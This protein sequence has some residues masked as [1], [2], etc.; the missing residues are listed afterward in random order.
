MRIERER[1]MSDDDH[2][3]LSLPSRIRAVAAAVAR[4]AY[5]DEIFVHA[6]A[7]TYYALLSIVPLLALVFAMVKA[8]GGVEERLD[9]LLRMFTADPAFTGKVVEF[10]RQVHVG[11]LTGLSSAFLL[12]TAY[13]LLG[14]IEATFNRIWRV[15]RGREWWRQIADYLSVFLLTPFLLVGAMGATSFAQEQTVLLWLLAEPYVAIFTSQVLHL[16]PIAFN[17]VAVAVLYTVMPNRRPHF[18]AI[19]PAAVVA[20]IALQ[21][22]QATYVKFQ[23][24]A[25]S[26]TLLYGALAQIPVMMLWIYWSWLVVLACAELAVVLEHGVSAESR[27]GRS[28]TPWA[29]GLAILVRAAES[30]RGGRGP[31]TLDALSSSLGMARPGVEQVAAQ[32]EASGFLVKVAGSRGAYVLAREPAG[33]DLGMIVSQLDGVTAPPGCDPRVGAILDRAVAERHAGL[34]R[35]TLADILEESAE[36]PAFTH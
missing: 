14:S 23:V 2:T 9:A 21:L 33:I 5:G 26:W 10:V 35:L 6:A 27:A 34:R 32:L 13:S 25:A 8:L 19:L 15:R 4:R 22:V 11:A 16:V 17:V 20:G 18:R 28:V 7:L 31:I 29:A 30:F 1:V 24:A 36:A 3:R 12:Y